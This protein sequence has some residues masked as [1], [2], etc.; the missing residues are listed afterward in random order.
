MAGGGASCHALLRGLR[1]AGQAMVDYALPPR[2]PG[3]GLIVGGD[4]QFCLDCWTSLQFLDGPACT[5]CSIPLP[6]A[7][8]GQ[9]VTCGACLADAPPF[10]GAPS[11][12]AYGPVARTVALRL[13][14]GRRMGHAR[15]MARLMQRPLAALV[16]EG[17]ALLIPIPLHRWRLWSRGFNQAGLIAD[18]LT[19]LGGVPHDHH[20]LLRARATPSLRGKGRR[21][22][23]RVV[24]GAFALGAD[25]KARAAGRHLV[26]IDDVHASGATLRAA[27]RVLKRSGAAQI[28]ALT[29]ARVVPDALMPGNPFDFAALDSD[30]KNHLLSG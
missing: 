23:E 20:L 24:A 22:R 5:R 25:A 8:P 29:W 3:C 30:M 14:Y 1:G 9:P 27:A 18:E 6:T 4:G 2:C 10:D 15:L 16:G 26:L 21:E 12:V 7:I 19:R 11:A 17:D 13:K 28:S